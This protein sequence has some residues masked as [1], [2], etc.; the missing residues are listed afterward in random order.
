MRTEGTREIPNCKSSPCTYQS[1]LVSSLTLRMKEREEI[2]S[3]SVL[4]DKIQYPRRQTGLQRSSGWCWKLAGTPC[5][6]GC[7]Q[8]LQ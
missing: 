6:A 4:G 5:Q 1:V 2:A 7:M 8:G 3:L